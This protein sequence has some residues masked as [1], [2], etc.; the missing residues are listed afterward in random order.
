MSPS[1]W[2]ESVAL[3]ERAQADRKGIPIERP[4]YVLA[5]EAMAVGDYSSADRYLNRAIAHL[6]D[7]GSDDAT[8]D[9]CRLY[10]EM[11]VRRVL[12]F[13]L[14]LAGVLLVAGPARAGTSDRTTASVTLVGGGLSLNVDGAIRFPETRFRGRD[15]RVFAERS[16]I[17]LTATDAT[18][19][20]DGWHVVLESTALTGP[21]GYGIP[22]AALSIGGRHGSV[23]TVSGSRPPAESVL[24]PTSLAA[25]VTVLSAEPGAGMGTYIYT[26]AVN[27]LHLDIPGATPTGHYFSRLGPRS[28]AVPDRGIRI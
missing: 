21:D 26:P 8:L 4:R 9:D 23:T 27:G 2:L 17:T 12:R 3:W 18:G 7:T 14:Y 13:K 28:R 1:L 11:A 6:I 16:A 19:R 24:R 10:Q 15:L 20:G 5:G 22:S 25:P